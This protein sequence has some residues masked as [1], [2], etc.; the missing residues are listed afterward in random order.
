MILL[1]EHSKI[2]ILS[3]GGEVGTTRFP[4]YAKWMQLE[5][6]LVSE[7]VGV[8]CEIHITQMYHV[9]VLMAL[10]EELWKEMAS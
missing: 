9:D 8:G 7:V 6:R 4:R 2:G 10:L 3:V 1:Q 5:R